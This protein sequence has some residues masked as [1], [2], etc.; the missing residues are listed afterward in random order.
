MK[1]NA[2]A[3]FEDNWTTISN[4]M[5]IGDEGTRTWPQR[6]AVNRAALI[7]IITAWESYVE[8]VVREVA[9]LMS[10]HCDSFQSLPKPVQTSI[11]KNVTPEKGFNSATPSRRR[12]QDLADD[13]WRTLLKEFAFEATAEG[14]F[15]TPSTA[16]VN[17]LFLNWVGIADIADSWAWQGFQAPRAAQRLDETIQLRGEVVHTGGK[18]DGLNRNWIRTYGESNIR[19]LVDRTDAV[20]IEH[21]NEVCQTAVWC[22]DPL[23]TQTSE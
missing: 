14:S 11:V 15:N 23:T 7:F 8:D 6:A 4:L 20:V 9:T 19:K 10:T 3:S 12:A 13:G 5:S 2:S 17:K 21:V 18:P 22:A 1:T 16:N